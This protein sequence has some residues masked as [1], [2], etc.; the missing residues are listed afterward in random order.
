MGTAPLYGDDPRRVCGQRVSGRKRTRSRTCIR[1]RLVFSPPAASNPSSHDQWR[2][3]SGDGPGKKT[4]GRGVGALHHTR[5]P[6]APPP[7]R[8]RRL[9][10][11]GRKA[12]WR[13]D[14]AGDHPPRTTRALLPSPI[15]PRHRRS[16]STRPG[17]AQPRQEPARVR[18]LARTSPRRRPVRRARVEGRIESRPLP[19][20]RERGHDLRSTS[21]ARHGRRASGGPAP[22]SASAALRAGGRGGARNRRQPISDVRLAFGRPSCSSHPA[23]K[24]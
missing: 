7:H 20:A 16:R 5:P 1:R 11:G 15:R 9:D 17:R 18:G 8:P 19:E 10:Q 3:R 6:Q 21:T 13:D 22:S 24:Q 2:C 14:R 23:Q 4:S 12:V